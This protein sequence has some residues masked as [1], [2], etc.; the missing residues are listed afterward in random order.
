[1]VPFSFPQTRLKS[2]VM[3]KYTSSFLVAH[4]V[5]NQ[6]LLPFPA[7]LLSLW[8]F[9]P[10]REKPQIQAKSHQ[11][12]VNP[13]FFIPTPNP[14]FWPLNNLVHGVEPNLGWSRVPDLRWIYTD[15]K[16]FKVI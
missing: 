1:M 16:G 12:K 13:L 7:F 5:W 10:V 14:K 6:V 15:L 11:I 3:Q 9:R 8:S 2:R 4:G